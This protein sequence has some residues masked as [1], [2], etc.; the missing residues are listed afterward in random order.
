MSGFVLLLILLASGSALAFTLVMAIKAL[1]NH[2]H[3]K[4]G[5][6]QSTSFVLCP[7][8]GESNKRQKNGQQCRA[9]YK[10]F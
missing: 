5:L 1:Q 4:K 6:D 3:H 10:V 7:S 8:C 9:C 2:L